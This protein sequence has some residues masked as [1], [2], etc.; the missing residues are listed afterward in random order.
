MKRLALGLL[1]G[2]TRYGGE[3]AHLGEARQPLGLVSHLT[4][5]VPQQWCQTRAQRVVCGVPCGAH[6]TEC[7]AHGPVL[8][9]QHVARHHLQQLR[10]QTRPT[11]SLVTRGKPAPPPAP[12]PV[13][14]ASPSLAPAPALLLVHGRAPAP[15]SH[16]PSEELST[17]HAYVVVK[18][19]VRLRGVGR[20]QLTLPRLV[21]ERRAR[22]GE[23]TQER[24]LKSRSGW[25]SST[26]R[27]ASYANVQ[28]HH[29]SDGQ[30][31]RVAHNCCKPTRAHAGQWSVET[32]CVTGL[33]HHQPTRTV[34]WGRC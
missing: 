31:P 5:S 28:A 34:G 32:S 22:T 33:R 4:A 9:P 13:V 30:P 11:G 10:G 18:L 21:G 19:G 24:S 25:P 6:R 8:P 3:E 16:P 23:E 1:V 26:A 27:D 29:C 14:S 7:S 2:L 17:P 20:V 15:R 12:P